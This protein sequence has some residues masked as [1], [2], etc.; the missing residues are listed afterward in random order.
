MVSLKPREPASSFNKTS[1]ATNFSRDAP[2]SELNKW[3]FK[4]HEDA[5]HEAAPCPCVCL[6]ACVFVCVIEKEGEG[7]RAACLSIVYTV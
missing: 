2:P 3:K 1:A 4:L 5:M 7:K 6:L